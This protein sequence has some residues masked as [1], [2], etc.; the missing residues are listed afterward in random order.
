M[1]EV[2]HAGDSSAQ[3]AYPCASVRRPGRVRAWCEALRCPYCGYEQQVVG[4][5]RR[6]PGALFRRSGALPRKPA[7]S[8]GAHVFVCQRCGAQTES[9]ALADRCQF[10]GGPVVA[11]AAAG[12]L[13]A[14]EAVLPFQRRP[15]R[16]AHGAAAMGVRRW[17]APSSLKKVSEAETLKGT[18]MPHW[19]FDAHTVTDLPR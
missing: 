15:Q 17:F 11:D 19:T 3:N 9:D 1:T 16:R 12:E 6:G 7:A 13:I 18:Y 4:A 5:G 8:I 2:T 10:C 14:P